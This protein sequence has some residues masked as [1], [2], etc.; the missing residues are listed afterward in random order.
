MLGNLGY[1]T[2]AKW[3]KLKTNIELLKLKKPKLCY[4]T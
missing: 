2:Q 1:L 4:L 3:P